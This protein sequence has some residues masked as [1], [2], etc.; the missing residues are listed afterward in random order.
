MV[1]KLSNFKCVDFYCISNYL[2]NKTIPIIKGP[3]I[4]VWQYI[5]WQVPGA[6]GVMFLTY[7][8]YLVIPIYKKGN[9]INIVSELSGLHLLFLYFIKYETRL[10][11]NNY[12]LTSV[13]SI[14]S[15]SSNLVSTKGDRQQ[16]MSLK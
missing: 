13:Y 10:R 11:I 7:L 3:Q 2:V 4:Y 12:H 6:G 16:L 1:S 8:K 14:S 5:T 9:R 15:L